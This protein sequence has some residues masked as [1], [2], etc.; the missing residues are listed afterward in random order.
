[1][2]SGLVALP[3]VR[4][5][6]PHQHLAFVVG[7]RRVGLGD[8]EGDLALL[9]RS[10]DRIGQVGEAQAALDEPAGAAE[11]FGNRVEVAAL[12]DEVLVGTDFI[13]RG[14]VETDHVLDQRQLGLL[15]GIDVEHAAGNGVI[16]G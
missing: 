7:R 13:G 4:E 15:G 16:L 5:L 8:V 1:M 11:P 6:V 10:E 3:A 9:E 12:I 2:E 14:H